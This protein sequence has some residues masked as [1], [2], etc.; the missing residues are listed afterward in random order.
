MKIACQENKVPGETF[1]EKV[2]NLE[3]FGFAGVELMHGRLAE[4]LAEVKQALKHIAAYRPARSAPARST[5]CW[6]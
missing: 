3:R 2:D 1:Q 6:A 5:I 4:R